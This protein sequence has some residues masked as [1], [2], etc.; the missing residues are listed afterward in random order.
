M[1]NSGFKILYAKF[2]YFLKLKWKKENGFPL[3]NQVSAY[4]FIHLCIIIIIYNK[5]QVLSYICLHH[6]FLLSGYFVLKLL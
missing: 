4:I 2:P 1:E 3:E 5:N 6:C